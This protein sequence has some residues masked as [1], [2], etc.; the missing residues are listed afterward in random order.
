[1][2]SEK[3]KIE[4]ILGESRKVEKIAWGEHVELKKKMRP[5]HREDRFLGH[6][7]KVRGAGKR[8]I[9]QS[10]GRQNPDFSKISDAAGK[11]KKKFLINCNSINIKYLLSTNCARYWVINEW[12]RQT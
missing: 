6:Q 4:S 3:I 11:W 1:M 12:T 5:E 7:G 10:Q 9:T 8:K 2:I